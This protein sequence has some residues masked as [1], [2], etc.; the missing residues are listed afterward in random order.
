[1]NCEPK[2]DTEFNCRIAYQRNPT[3]PKFE[4]NLLCVLNSSVLTIKPFNVVSHFS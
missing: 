4:V 2:V 1:M 3:P